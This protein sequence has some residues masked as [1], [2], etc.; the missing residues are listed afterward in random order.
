MMKYLSRYIK[1]PRC[2]SKVRIPTY[3]VLGVEGIFRCPGCKLPF[4]TGYRMGAV[5]F[6]LALAL[7]LTCAQLLIYIFS[8][9]SLP[10]F[11]LFVIPMWVLYG[12][13]MRKAYM[14]WRV[15]RILKKQ[16]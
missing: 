9:Y 16:A 8:S 12:F 14:T 3:W 7:S 11:V 15:R 1:C 5:L 4:K 13:I 2:G 10:L 6:A